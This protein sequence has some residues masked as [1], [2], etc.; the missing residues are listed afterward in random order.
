M[1]TLVKKIVA[2][3]CMVMLSICFAM[4]Q[5]NTIKH[6]V[7]RGETLAS[8]AKRYATTEAKIIE[9]NP[10]AAQFIY[11][12]MELTIPVTGA[13]TTTIQNNVEPVNTYVTEQQN[14]YNYNQSSNSNTQTYNENNDFQRWTPSFYLSYGFLPK[15]KGG[16]GIKTSNMN[17][18]LSFGVN[19]SI[20]ESFYVGA[21]LGFSWVLTHIKDKAYSDLNTTTEA[22]FINLPIELGYRIFLDDNHNTAIIPYAG[23]DLDYCIKNTTE[24]GTG[25]SATK[26]KSDNNK[27]GVNG[28]V[29]LR[30]RFSEFCLGAAYVFVADKNLKSDYVDKT[31]GYFEVSL[32]YSM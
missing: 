24:I 13:N 29:G 17:M 5:T 15:P 31:N 3:T 9:L 14:S 11:V 27:I 22:Y 12:G 19:Y 25:K 6:T 2:T 7:D 30:L 32:G 10:D 20:T 8:I 16:D 18:A 1:K 4:A 26:Y 23:I 28:R 21:R